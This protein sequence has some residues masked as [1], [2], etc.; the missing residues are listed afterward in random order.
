[1]IL[2]GDIGGTNSRLALFERGGRV[3]VRQEAFPS[4]NFKSLEEVVRR[5]LGKD[6]PKIAAATFGIAGPVVSGRAK[7]TNLPWIVDGRELGRHLDIPRVTLV[8]D[9]VALAFGTL[10]VP[11]DKLFMLNGGPPRTSG[12]NIA[13]I[14]AGTGLGEAALVW[15]G[16]KHVPLGTEGGHADFAARNAEECQLL[17]FLQ[18]RY[19]SH[20]SCERVVAGPGFAN[21]YDFFSEVEGLKDPP[22]VA[23]AIAGAADRNREIAARGADET[24]PIGARALATFVGLYGAEAGN[25]ALK[26][27]ATGGVFV[28]GAI[29]AKYKDALKTKGFMESFVA[30]G[31][32]TGFLECV[33]VAIVLDSDIGLAGSALYAATQLNLLPAG[34]E[35]NP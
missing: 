27:L 9:L 3:R 29:A 24:S 32:F 17:A 34:A 26:T 13:V 1:V 22:D 12:G 21:L 28:C 16:E 10:T 15:D 25:L 11:P 18:R 5:F 30:K 6:P 35:S 19:G 20:V 8:N 31:R 2:A 4:R 14:A 33:P 7:A 23:A